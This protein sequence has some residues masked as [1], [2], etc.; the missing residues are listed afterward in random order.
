MTT[1][2]QIHEFNKKV[3]WRNFLSF[4]PEFSNFV[5]QKG[6]EIWQQMKTFS[7]NI[8]KIMPASYA[9]NELL[10]HVIDE[11]FC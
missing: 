1:R 11:T 4:T 6:H 5:I 3:I 8:S 9:K 2:A 10:D 7:Q